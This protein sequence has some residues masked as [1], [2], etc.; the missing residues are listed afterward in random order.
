MATTEPQA[1]KKYRVG[2]IWDDVKSLKIKKD[3]SVLLAWIMLRRGWQVESIED[4]H[5]CLGEDGLKAWAQTIAMNL[6]S[7]RAPEHHDEFVLNSGRWVNLKEFDI[8][9]MRKDPPVDTHYLKLTWLLGE[10]DCP[11]AVFSPP[12]VLSSYNEKLLAWK[13]TKPLGI[14]SN[15]MTEIK[16]YAS[17]NSAVIIKPLNAMGGENVYCCHKGD[18]N[19]PVILENLLGQHSYLMVQPRL[20]A[21]DTMGDCRVLVIHGQPWPRGLTRMPTA[22]DHRGNMSKGAR[23]QINDLS[24]AQHAMAQRIGKWLMKHEI[25]LAG[26]DFIGDQLTEVNITSPT[27]VRELENLGEKGIGEAIVTSIADLTK[28]NL[29]IDSAQ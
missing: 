16:Q 23:V 27:G 19:I 1:E 22:G 12:H 8:V 21:I 6:E 5:L 11:P 4:R 26:L 13:F 7:P 15:D 24:S 10:L 3:T 18:S 17:D 2:L 29:C 9:L 25:P 14:V 20:P 28:K